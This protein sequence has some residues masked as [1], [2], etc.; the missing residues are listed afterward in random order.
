MGPFRRRDRLPAHQVGRLSGRRADIRADLAWCQ[1][2]HHGQENAPV[3]GPVVPGKNEQE[4][5]RRG[6][7]LHRERDRVRP[8]G[9]VAENP[10]WES[11]CG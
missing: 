11:A 7:W 5:Y 4:V 2:G 9:G 1:D 6:F 8:L 3:H 10:V